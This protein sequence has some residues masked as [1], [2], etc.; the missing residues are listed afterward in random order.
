MHFLWCP[1]FCFKLSLVFWRKKIGQDVFVRKI[2]AFLVVSQILFLS[3]ACFLPARIFCSRELGLDKIVFFS[4][5]SRHICGCDCFL[6]CNFLAGSTNI[7]FTKASCKDKFQKLRFFLFKIIMFFLSKYVKS[8]HV[9]K[10]CQRW[11][12]EVVLP[13]NHW[14]S[15]SSF[16]KRCE[17]V[18]E[19]Q[20][21]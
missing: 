17:E 16:L 4:R 21:R 5:C 3:F 15:F 19:G 13:Q 20:N 11:E 8:Y 9:V 12:T 7:R 10:L 2:N 18:G 6:F 1:K 14:L